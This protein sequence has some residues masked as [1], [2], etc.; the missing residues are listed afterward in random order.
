MAEE[1]LDHPKIRPSVEQVRG[2][3]VPKGVGVRG[4]R[5]PAIEDPTNIARPESTS[6]SVE[7]QRR[8]G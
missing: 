5:G 7:E 6:P 1:L 2:V 4:P 8:S 3:G